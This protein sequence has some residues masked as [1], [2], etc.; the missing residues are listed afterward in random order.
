M[1]SNASQVFENI[2]K[3]IE[4]KAPELS[5]GIVKSMI[6][7]IVAG[8][9]EIDWYLSGQWRGSVNVSIDEPDF[10]LPEPGLKSYPQLDP[11]EAIARLNGIKAEN[12][13]IITLPQPY[14]RA[15]EVDGWSDKAPAG[16]VLDVVERAGANV[17]V[18]RS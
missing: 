9:N 17:N 12:V 16:S 15:L 5:V 11:E 13:A 14:T 3:D 7:Q 4:V 10:S 1:P 6:G 18:P 8:I 2:K